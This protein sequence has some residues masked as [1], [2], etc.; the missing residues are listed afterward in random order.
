MVV[1]VWDILWGVLGFEDQ[2]P[3][4]EKGGGIPSERWVCP[5]LNKISS[6]P[7][8]V[9]CPHGMQQASE[10]PTHD[11]RHREKPG[12]EHTVKNAVML[13]IAQ[14]T[15]TAAKSRILYEISLSWAPPLPPCSPLWAFA[16]VIPSL[17]N[18]LPLFCF[19]KNSYS[20]FKIT[21]CHLP[22]EHP[23]SLQAN[24]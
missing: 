4:G 1:D 17:R 16:F 14:R 10:P 7:H 23:P 13:A 11:F 20:P 9:F 21:L 5:I 2:Y 8:I 15:Y 24:A 19:L 12:L 18:V 3:L 22:M 6:F